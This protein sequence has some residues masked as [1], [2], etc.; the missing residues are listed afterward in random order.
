MNFE[1]LKRPSAIGSLPG[2][3]GGDNYIIYT[4]PLQPHWSLKG[5]GVQWKGSK[6]TRAFMAGATKISIL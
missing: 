4:N 1:T 5:S 6:F 2:C 3:G